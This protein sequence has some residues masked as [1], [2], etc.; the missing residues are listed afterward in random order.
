MC[1]EL[2]QALDLQQLGKSRSSKIPVVM[3]RTRA[4]HVNFLRFGA[5]TQFFIGIKNVR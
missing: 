1:Q 4:S 3:G 5:E 2:F